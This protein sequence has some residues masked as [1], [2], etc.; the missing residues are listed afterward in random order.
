[1][2]TTLWRLRLMVVGAPLLLLLLLPSCSDTV[3]PGDLV[4]T[5]HAVELSGE[6]EG[7]PFDFLDEGGSLSITLAANGTTT[8]TLFLPGAGEAGEDINASMAGTWAYDEDTNALTFDQAADTYVRDA[9]WTVDG[10]RIEGSFESDDENF[11]TTV[12][13]K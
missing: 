7:V 1:M 9:T 5:Y 2:T 6:D 10:D 11:V 13:E 8:G 3:E 4:G 12:L